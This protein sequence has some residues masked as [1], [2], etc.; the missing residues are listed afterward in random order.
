MAQFSQGFL[1]SLGRPEMSQSLFGLGAA[2]GGVPA[3]LQQRK[4]KQEETGMLAG[5]VAG[6]V[7]YNQALAQIAQQ[8]G[9]LEKAAQFGSIAREQELRE[10]QQ[11][12]LL[13]S[14]TAT[15]NLLM[16]DLTQ[17][18]NNSKLSEGQRTKARNLLKVAAVQGE[19][20]SVLSPQIDALKKEIEGDRLS[21]LEAANLSKN[22]KPESVEKYQRTRNVNDLRINEPEEKEEVTE[23]TRLVRLAG[24]E[25]DSEQS[26]QLHKA[27]AESLSKFNVQTLGPVAQLAEL[28]DAINKTPSAKESQKSISQAQKAIA[29]LNSVKQRM[30]KGEPVSEQVRVIER[31]VSELYNSDS[32]AASEIDRFLRGKGIKRASIDWV[33]GVLTG[34]T[35]TET[36]NLYQEMAETV[37]GFSKNQLKNLASPFIEMFDADKEVVNK[38]NQ[39]YYIS[40]PSRTS[41]TQ[42]PESPEISPDVINKYLK[43]AGA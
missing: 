10:Q 15:A 41:T 21:L 27:R 11:A 28:R 20:A 36:L 25:D 18:M 5:L 38:L 35:S 22:W 14:Q 3:Q 9:E 1:S 26:Q 32:R 39:I 29:T 6:S 13:Q 43:E 23:F 2:I 31:T 34:E 16:N 12:S 37:E 42:T 8:R 30:A 19:R 7:E 40:E 17:M 24:W 33:S 4:Q